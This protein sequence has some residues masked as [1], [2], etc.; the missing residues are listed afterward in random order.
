MGDFMFY[1]RRCGAQILTEA[2]LCPECNCRTGVYF[3][4]AKREDSILVLFIRAFIV[5][6]LFF[7]VLLIIPMAWVIP[8][9]RKIFAKLDSGEE[10]SL[11]LKII[12]LLFVNPFAG[13]LM[14]FL[15]N[16]RPAVYTAKTYPI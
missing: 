3:E 10:I 8:L 4:E 7:S 2:V 13:I 1:C 14:F 9:K 16:E 6:S 12:T 15:K 5:V 11:G